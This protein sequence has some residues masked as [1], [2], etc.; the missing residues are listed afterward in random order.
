ME[1]SQPQTAVPM[2]ASQVND[3]A[4][5]ASSVETLCRVLGRIGLLFPKASKFLCEF[6]FVAEGVVCGHERGC[7]MFKLT[8]FALIYSLHLECD[9]SMMVA[10]KPAL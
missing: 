5:R 1:R 7:D 9:V 6:F 3:E 10:S 2:K 4:A 8:F